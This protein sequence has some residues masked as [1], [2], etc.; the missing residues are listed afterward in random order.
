MD[1]QASQ[2]ET[3]I[4]AENWLFISAISPF[5]G[6]VG[7]KNSQRQEESCEKRRRED[8]ERGEG[9]REMRGGEGYEGEEK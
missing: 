2:E 6:T 8:G 5:F 4:G 3:E 7:L 1:E 9:A